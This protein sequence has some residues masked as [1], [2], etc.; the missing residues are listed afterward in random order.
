MTPTTTSPFCRETGG[1]IHEPPS[2][3][4][5]QADYYQIKFDHIKKALE[6]PRLLEIFLQGSKLPAG[7]GIGID[8]RCIEYLYFF[9]HLPPQSRTILD[10]G[11]TL[12]H[13]AVIH[14]SALDRKNLH[15]ATLAPEGNCFWRKGISYLFTD[16]RS[17]PIK[18]NYYD[19]IV[20]ISTIEHVGMDNF[21]IT[22][23]TAHHE[24]RPKDFLLAIKELWRVLKPN[25]T[26]MLTVPFGR[27]TNLGFALQFDSDL[28]QELIMAVP[29]VEKKIDFYKYFPTGWQISSAKECSQCLF[30]EWL[31]KFLLNPTKGWPDPIPVEHDLAAG[32][33]AV[34]CIRLTK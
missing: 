20:S 19:C 2:H 31:A 30:V 24:S 8:E 13:D 34:A 7:Y 17:I 14:H 11:S 10:A 32:A 21:G 29:F 16:F 4:P 23:Q 3:I 5:W 9:A 26:L 27:Y 18:D 6:N 33:R 28:L 15:I 12:N 22:G 1:R 25:G